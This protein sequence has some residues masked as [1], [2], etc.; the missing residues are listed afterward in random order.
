MKTLN[1]LVAFVFAT[2]SFSVNAQT[3]DAVKKE[4]VKVWGNCEMCQKHIEKAAKEAGAASAKWS[5]ETQILSVTYNP[6]KASLDKIEKSVAAAGYDTDH[7]T[8]DDKA[9]NKLHTCCQY[10]R[11]AASSKEAEPKT[12]Q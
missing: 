4:T 3:K 5:S 11:K 8:A 10:D 9:Y 12:N 7:Q 2:I 6:S 1:I